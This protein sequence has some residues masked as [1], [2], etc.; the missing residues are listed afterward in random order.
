MKKYL[1]AF[2]F[3]VSNIIYSQHPISGVVEYKVEAIESLESLNFNKIDEEKKLDSTKKKELIN[4]LTEPAYFVLEFSSFEST[5]KN[6]EISMNSDVEKKQKPNLFQ[7]FGGGVSCN[8][9]TNSIDK[10]ILAE[11]FSFGELLIIKQEFPNWEITR[12]TKKI[13]S[14]TCFKAIKKIK[15]NQIEEVWY[16]PDIPVQFG[17][18]LK[19]GLPG[20]VLEVI[21][22]GKFRIIATKINIDTNANI[23]IIKPTKGKQITIDTYNKKV[24]EMANE[25][26]F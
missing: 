12:E 23:H 4:A 7:I 21:S 19:I 25:L 10:I 11:K 16:T 22:S 6:K 13:D 8:Y 9:Y 24:E 17:P 2:I 14:F 15:N 1:L 20:L 18:E 3:C 26:G 5:Y